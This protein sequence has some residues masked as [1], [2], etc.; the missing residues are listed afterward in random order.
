MGRLAAMAVTSETRGRDA[1]GLAWIDARGRLRTY[2]RPGAA[3]ARLT[4]LQAVEGARVVLGHCRWATQGEPED[5]INNHPHPAGKGMIVH[6][7][8][9]LNYIDLIEQHELEPAGD[10]DSEVLGMLLGAGKGK[11]L[12]DHAVDTVNAV[13]G[14]IAVAGVWSNPARVVIAKRGKPLHIGRAS[15]GYY[16]ASLEHGLPPNA[17]EFPENQAVALRIGREHGL[18]PLANILAERRL[19]TGPAAV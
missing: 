12:I 1:F 15:R 2:K 19:H 18:E 3:S 13:H 11:R 5:N 6:N 8:T 16:F 17:V 9:L 10:C 14:P 4:D 7:G